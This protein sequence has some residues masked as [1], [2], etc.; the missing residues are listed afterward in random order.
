MKVISK[1]DTTRLVKG[2]VYDVLSIKASPAMTKP[3][4]VLKEIGW[5]PIASFTNMDG[6]PIERKDWTSP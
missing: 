1:K 3:Y 5:H 4:L 2:G 6:T